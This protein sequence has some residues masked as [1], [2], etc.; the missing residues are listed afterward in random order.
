MRLD[1]LG[2]LELNELRPFVTLVMDELR[3]M[4]ST[5]EVDAEDEDGY[6]S[7]DDYD[8]EYPN[9]NNQANTQEDY[10]RDQDQNQ[11]QNNVDNIDLDLDL[12]LPEDTT[13]RITDFKTS[14]DNYDEFDESGYTYEYLREKEEREIQAQ[15]RQAV[16]GSNMDLD[17]DQHHQ[18]DETQQIDGG[19]HGPGA[20]NRQPAVE[21]H[22]MDDY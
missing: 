14:E 9:Y 15:Q 1:N 16:A 5:L 17:P 22:E 11:N 10:Q 20:T 19:T 4:V 3:R 6:D 2:T 8:Y 7:D 21:D 12:S 13:A 18:D